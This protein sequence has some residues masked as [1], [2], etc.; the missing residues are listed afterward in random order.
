MIIRVTADDLTTV[1]SSLQ[2]GATEIT[3]HLQ[4]MQA[5]VNN[6]IEGG[7]Q[8]AASSQF[9]TLYQQWNQGAGQLNQA[10][11][12][13]STLLSNAATTYAQTEQAIAQ[14]MQQG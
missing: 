14:S 8:G 11:Q 13:I 10:L 4:S 9:G 3:S 5:Q 2:S 12:G 7:W 6:L 1:S